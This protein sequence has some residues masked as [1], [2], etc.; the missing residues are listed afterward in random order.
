MGVIIAY[1]RLNS[2]STYE[3]NVMP[4][5]DVTV[6]KHGLKYRCVLTATSILSVRLHVWNEHLYM[7][8]AYDPINYYKSY[9][10]RKLRKYCTNIPVIQDICGRSQA[11]TM[12]ARIMTLL[13]RQRCF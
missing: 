11:Y 8:L 3:K 6:S 12:D 5:N 10:S 13:V 4:R 1:M 9:C 2:G 7:N